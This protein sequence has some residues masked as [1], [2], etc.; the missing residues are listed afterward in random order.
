MLAML[1]WKVY[2]VGYWND[3]F[4]T[5]SFSPGIIHVKWSKHHYNFTVFNETHLIHIFFCVNYSSYF[6][7]TCK[8]VFRKKSKKIFIFVLIFIA[9][10]ESDRASS[11]Q[12]QELFKNGLPQYLRIWLEMLKELLDLILRH[13]C[14]FFMLS[15][16][17]ML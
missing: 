17:C 16:M 5:C 10:C 9:S 7:N 15:S 11:L 14:W 4:F 12:K 2:L 8:K 3:I 13:W 6:N 1:E